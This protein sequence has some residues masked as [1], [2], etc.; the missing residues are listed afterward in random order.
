MIGSG[1][2]MEIYEWVGISK[3]LNGGCFEK[4]SAVRLYPK[5]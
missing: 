5:V 1:V 3:I 2:S 4:I